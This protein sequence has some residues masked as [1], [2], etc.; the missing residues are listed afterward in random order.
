VGGFAPPLPHILPNR[1]VA[2]FLFYVVDKAGVELIR[3]DGGTITNNHQLL[4]SSGQGYIHAAVIFQETNFSF[5]VATNQADVDDFSLLSLEAIYGING[6]I[7]V[8]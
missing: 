4:L 8:A 6:Q 2:S 3:C 1:P 7:K 5:F